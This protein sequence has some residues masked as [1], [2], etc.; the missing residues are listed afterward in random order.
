MGGAGRS[1]GKRASI[2]PQLSVRNGRAAIDFYRA[3]FGAVEDYRVGGTDAD[4]SVVAQ[5]SVGDASFWVSDEA[6]SHGSFSPQTLGGATAR[7]L[8][9]SKTRT[10]RSTRR[11]RPARGR[12]SRSARS[13]AGAWG[14]SRIPSATP[15]RS[16]GR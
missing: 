1:S 9:T 8:L 10:V 6:P 16:E 14:G 5:L 13:T 11:W 3:A 15:G 7:M 12:C 2:P 4:E